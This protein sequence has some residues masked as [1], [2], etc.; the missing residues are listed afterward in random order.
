MTADTARQMAIQCSCL[1][2]FLVGVRPES[3]VPVLNDPRAPWEVRSKTRFETYG[4]ILRPQVA[5]QGLATLEPSAAFAEQSEPP[6]PAPRSYMI[7]TVQV[8]DLLSQGQTEFRLAEQ[9]T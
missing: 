2:V 1:G 8:F 3:A 4:N 5:H 7:R 6:S 9:L